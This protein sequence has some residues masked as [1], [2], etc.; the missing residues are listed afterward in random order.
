MYAI[1]VG[2]G[3]VGSELATL[4]SQRGHDV[5]IID[6]VG[7]SFSHLD[8]AWREYQQLISGNRIQIIPSD[9]IKAGG[10]FVQGQMGTVDARVETQMK[11]VLEVFNQDEPTEQ[12]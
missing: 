4:L 8:P 6:H 10:C 5:T 2:C 12:P 1:I 9:G 3:R 11:A 7:S